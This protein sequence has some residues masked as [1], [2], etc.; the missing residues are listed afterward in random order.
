MTL[1]QT[2][3][4][5]MDRILFDVEL[6]EGR[7]PAFVV[8]GGNLFSSTVKKANFKGKRYAVWSPEEDQYLRENHGWKTEEEIARHLGRTAVSVHLR[9]KRDLHLPAP[10]RHP[11]YIV[12]HQASQLIGVDNHCIVHWCDV[13]IIPS[14]ALPSERHIRVIYRKSFDRWVVSPS[15]WIYFDW[16]HI[17][18][19]RL[20]RLCELRA[21]RWGDEWWT[22]KQVAQFHG[23]DVS[24]QD[25]LR[26]IMRSEIPAVQISASRSGR[27]KNPTWLNWFV[28]KSDAV[29]AV[30]MRGS[31]AGRDLQFSARADAWMLKARFELG[32]SWQAIAR[33]MKMDRSREPIRKH[34]LKLV[35]DTRTS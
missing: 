22:T 8:A 4:D 18:D 23:K 30:F 31:G 26:L 19:P 5:L 34:I 29:K 28:R 13:G 24:T 20:R 6:E 1:D 17:P 15:S 25:V 33:S 11:D 32:M 9:W 12:A 7:A 21:A 14:R 35:Q 3:F 2:T 16:T 27:H 10:S